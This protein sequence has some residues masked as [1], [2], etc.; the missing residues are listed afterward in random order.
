[1]TLT[2]GHFFSSVSY[3]LFNQAIFSYIVS[4]P[5]F[6][7]PPNITT[8]LKFFH[9]SLTL[10]ALF[11]FEAFLPTSS[12]AH[13]VTIQTPTEYHHDRHSA[14]NQEGFIRITLN[15]GIWGPHSTML[16]TSLPSLGMFTFLILLLL[17]NFLP[18]ALPFLPGISKW[19]LC[20]RH[21]VSLSTWWSNPLLFFSFPF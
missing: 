10:R 13:L 7:I 5:F 3:I 2:S 18:L 21:S 17:P 11:T 12:I 20:S 8:I 15:P 19:A 1:M 14:G 4:P 6:S 9:P 16:S